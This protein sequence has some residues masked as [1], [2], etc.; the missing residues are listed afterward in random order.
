M[1]FSHESF[2][3]ASFFPPSFSLGEVGLGGVPFL[4]LFDTPCI[5]SYSAALDPVSGVILF[6]VRTPVPNEN[7]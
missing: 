6:I 4:L 2:Q 1:Q 5:R 7:R 3:K